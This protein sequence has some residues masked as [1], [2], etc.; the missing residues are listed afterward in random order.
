MLCKAEFES[1]FR[2]VTRGMMENYRK[3]LHFKIFITMKDTLLLYF[4][5]IP[6]KI[7][8][9]A[10]NTVNSWILAYSEAGLEVS[11]LV[12]LVTLC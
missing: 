8:P 4:E 7:L 9:F 3:C 10:L 12:S 1:V 11:F 6:F 2:R 5:L